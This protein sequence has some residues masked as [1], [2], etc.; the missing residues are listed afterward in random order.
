M[1][2]ALRTSLQHFYRTS[3][4]PCPYIDGRTERKLITEL[5]V[6]TSVPLY[7]DLS[8]AGFRRSHR[9]AYRPACTAC[10]ACL[11][12]RIVVEQHEKSRSNRRV[13]RMNHDLALGLEPAEATIEQYA[14]FLR[15]QQGR[16]GDSDMATMN[17]DD[18]RAMI[19]DSPLDTVLVTARLCDTGQL[20]GVCLTDRLDDGCSAVYSFFEPDEPRRSLGTWL[21]LHLVEHMRASSLP[22]VYLG[23]WVEGSAKMDY[24]IRF[25]PLE[26]LWSGGWAA[27][28]EI[29]LTVK[30]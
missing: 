15:Y 13:L 4:Q 3:A 30:E 12:V 19:E 10:M 8:R 5:V 17:F 29:D 6:A 25:R 22:Y 21:V 26:A 23:Y 28:E 2:T 1:T 27:L 24:K 16:H 7:N 18:Y 20:M 11:P 14:L 9:L